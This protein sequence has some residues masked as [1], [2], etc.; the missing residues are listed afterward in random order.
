MVVVAGRYV[1]IIHRERENAFN[2]SSLP[3]FRST[4]MQTAG[5]YVKTAAFSLHESF[6][7]ID[8]VVILVF[9]KK[10]I[11]SNFIVLRG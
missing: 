3:I 2:Y 9:L 7:N 8:D 1:G 6:T 5:D 10:F 11:I 4:L